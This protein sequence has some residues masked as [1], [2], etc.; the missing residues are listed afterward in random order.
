MD[1]GRASTAFSSVDRA[2]VERVL[3]GS[4][5]PAGP[6]GFKIEGDRVEFMA[7]DKSSSCSLDRFVSA[8]AEMSG[9]PLR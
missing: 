7:G 8:L 9:A 2:P 1:E 3:V 5:L 4:T 6:F